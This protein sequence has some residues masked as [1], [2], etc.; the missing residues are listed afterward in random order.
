MNIRFL[1]AAVNVQ[2]VIEGFQYIFCTFMLYI[3]F[4]PDSERVPEWWP[5]VQP[6]RNSTHHRTQNVRTHKLPTRMNPALLRSKPSCPSKIFCPVCVTMGHVATSQSTLEQR[7][8]QKAQVCRYK[9][10]N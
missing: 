2:M 1:I 9:P 7:C 5:C 8:R 6:T 4:I 3:A 10:D